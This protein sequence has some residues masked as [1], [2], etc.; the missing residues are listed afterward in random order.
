MRTLPTPWLTEP[1]R[2][3]PRLFCGSK[4]T[5]LDEKDM[6]L[7]PPDLDA[8]VDAEKQWARTFGIQTDPF[9]SHRELAAWDEPVHPHTPQELF[10]LNKTALDVSDGGIFHDYDGGSTM[11]GQWVLRL[12][13]SPR[14]VPVLVV[15]HTSEKVSKALEGALPNY[16]NLTLATFDNPA[17]LQRVV[18]AWLNQHERRL[19]DGPR[20][21]MML[22]SAWRSNA[23]MMTSAWELADPQTRGHAL[24]ALP[25]SEAAVSELLTRP[26]LLGE[27]P[28]GNLLTLLTVLGLNIGY[29]S[30]AHDAKVLLDPEEIAAWR[31]WSADHRPDYAW[32]ALTA[33]ISDRREA[34]VFRDPDYLAQPGAWDV[35]AAKESSRRAQG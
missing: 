11:L 16:P 19:I 14:L 8:I 5:G 27:C 26:E 12:L 7:L 32:W 6:R 3:L 25:Y 10:E 9:F 17:D 35:Y 31:R 15:A 29:A 18:T 33:L 20:R 1:L 24:A 28:S 34:G 21:R 13:E 23:S 22:D 30:A 4:Q 2:Y